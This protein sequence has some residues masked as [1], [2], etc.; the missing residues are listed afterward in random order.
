MERKLRDS[1]KSSE[2]GEDPQVL[3]G[4]EKAHPPP[5][6]NQPVQAILYEHS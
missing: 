5:C 3:L 6:G 1:S 4:T 2:A